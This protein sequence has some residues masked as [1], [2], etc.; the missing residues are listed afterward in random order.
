MNFHRES[1][2]IDLKL[3]SPIVINNAFFDFLNS[4]FPDFIAVYTDGS[5]SPLSAGYSF[6]IPELH[7]SFTNNLPPSASSF[8]A[9]CFAIVK[10]LTLISSFLPDKFLIATD[11]MSCLQSFTSNPFN[12]QIS[13]LIL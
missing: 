1:P 5:V 9:E 2:S 12:F 7:I 11:S 8:T 6:Y 3:S 13:P 4:I 10:T